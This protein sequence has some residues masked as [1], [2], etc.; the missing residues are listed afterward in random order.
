VECRIDYW[1]IAGGISQEE[2]K[3]IAAA[4]GFGFELG[5]ISRFENA[6]NAVVI[7]KPNLQ[8]DMVNRVLLAEELQHGHD[9]QRHEAARAIQRGLSN[10]EFHVELFERL[11]QHHRTGGFAFL[12]SDDI[13]GII[14]VVKELKP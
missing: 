8:N 1:E 10:V 13:Q 5:R 6:R 12:S 7:A 4:E 9:R 14:K 3:A 2:A 11:L